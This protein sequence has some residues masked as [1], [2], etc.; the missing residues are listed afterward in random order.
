MRENSSSKL[1]VTNQL[2]AINSNKSKINCECGRVYHVN[3][4]LNQDL[5]SMSAMT[6]ATT[7][8]TTTTKT[9]NFELNKQSNSN[10]NN[11]NNKLKRISSTK[12]IN[13]TNNNVTNNA[14]NSKK[15]KFM[16][17]NHSLNNGQK[18]ATIMKDQT[19]QSFECNQCRKKFDDIHVATAHSSKCT[20]Q[21]QPQNILS[22]SS[23]SSLDKDENNNH[24][25]TNTT[26]NNQEQVENN[27]QQSLQ[28]ITN[29]CDDM[30]SDE[31]DDDTEYQNDIDELPD[32]NHSLQ[33]S[34][35]IPLSA[36][37]FK[38]QTSNNNNNNG[39]HNNNNNENGK[40]K[41]P[42]CS[43]PYS[44]NHTMLRHKMSIHD[45]HIKYCCKICDRSF[46][47]K[48]KLAT[49]ISNHQDYDT[50]VCFLCDCKLKSKQILKTHFKK[51]H[52]LNG[53]EA[54][55]NEYI[56]KCQIKETIDIDSNMIINYGD[57][58]AVSNSSSSS[59]PAP[60]HQQPMLNSNSISVNPG[61]SINSDNYQS[62]E[63]SL[64]K[65][66][67]SNLVSVNND[68][69]IGLMRNRKSLVYDILNTTQF[70]NTNASNIDVL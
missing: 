59:T 41:C 16:A 29:D 62:V 33:Q 49:H 11:N 39:I 43:K 51:D 6:S 8:T 53:D 5:T 20:T 66:V 69:T 22:S 18:I 44:N 57:T 35:T 42:V 50:Y 1:G 25:A 7:T 21:Q 47:R 61:V 68:D 13:L 24:E 58:S 38:Q 60:Q 19:Q 31:I 14:N 4:S 27:Q 65:D 67:D 48:D 17:V 56:L 64:K 32:N 70:D 12:L 23:S 26:S 54:N 55:Y 28:Q 37:A 3:I 34:L 30:N 40:I 45:K 15:M 2:N 63:N 46:F 10:N 52:N 9:I 36:P